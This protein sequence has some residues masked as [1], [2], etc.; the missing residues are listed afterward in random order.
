MDRK[1]NCSLS[2]E[3]RVSKN[4]KPYSCLVATLENGKSYIVSF[5]TGIM[6]NICN[7]IMNI[8]K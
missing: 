7:E 4:G 6:L 2:V 1:I 3:N 5:D 8:K